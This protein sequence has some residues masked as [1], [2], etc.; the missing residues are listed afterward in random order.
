MVLKQYSF[1]YLQLEKIIGKLKADKYGKKILDAIDNYEPKHQMDDD[2][3][4]EGQGTA[5]RAAKKSRT[6]KGLVVIDTSGDEAWKYRQ[7]Q[8]PIANYQ[9]CRFLRICQQFFNDSSGERQDIAGRATNELRGKKLFLSLNI[10][11]E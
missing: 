5:G 3:S 8:N 1:F 2:F 4:D 11:I 10:A 7:C 6:K 9:Y